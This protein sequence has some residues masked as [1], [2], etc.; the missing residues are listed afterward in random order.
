MLSRSRVA[1][2]AAPAA[3]AATLA[4][5]GLTAGA[6]GAPAVTSGI[7]TLGT[8]DDAGQPT[9]FPLYWSSTASPASLVVVFHGHGHDA[10]DWDAAGELSDT[11][12]RDN[13]VVVAPQ[14]T[15]TSAPNGQ[16]TFDTVDEEARDAAAAIAWARAT[17]HPAHTYL[18]CVSMGCT[19]L[20][21]FIDALARPS[22]G[23][24]DATFVQAQGVGRITGLLISEGLSNLVETWAEA[25]AADPVSRAEIEQETGGTP[26]N[27]KGG[28]RSRSFALLKSGRIS[29]LLI[30][31]AAVVHDVDD[32]LVPANQAA[33]TRAAL[34]AAEVAFH[35]YTVVRNG[36]AK[37]DTSHQTTG[38]SYVGAYAE[39]YTGSPVVSDNLDKTVCLAGHAS[40]NSPDTPVMH[41]TFNVLHDMTTTGIGPGETPVSILVK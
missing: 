9:T 25:S 18:L 40:E 13:A 20:A 19:G 15:V 14:T 24:A 16:G 17:Y 41:T 31:E 22:T 33:E 26:S 6:S 30:Q 10:A 23:D 3:V 4:A 36:T 27:A 37:C 39:Q 7:T 35:G 1:R 34:A 21:Y 5:A 28:Y 32:G 11:A 29:R 8:I 12:A 2:I 38:T